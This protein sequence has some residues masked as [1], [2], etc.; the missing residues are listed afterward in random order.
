MPSKLKKQL[1][2]PVAASLCW[3]AFAT[4]PASSTLSA[5]RAGCT[6]AFCDACAEVSKVCVEFGPVCACV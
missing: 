2:V 6:Q 3:L 5:Q 4:T 1:L